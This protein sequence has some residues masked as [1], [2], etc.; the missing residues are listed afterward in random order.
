MQRRIWVLLVVVV[1]VLLVAA[2]LLGTQRDTLAALLDDAIA[3]ARL[4]RLLN[5]SGV[6]QLDFGPT[7]DPALVALGEALFFDKLLSGNRDI[8]CATC[9]PPA[10]AA[11]GGL[12]LSL[13]ADSERAPRNIADLFNRGSPEWTTLFWDG[14]V[15]LSADGLDTPAGDA[16][17]P[18]LETALQAQAMFPVIAREEMRGFAGDHTADGQLNEL[19][20]AGDTEFSVIWAR[21]RQRLLAAPGYVELFRAA[22]PAVPTEQLRFEH[23]AVALAAYEAAAFTFRDSPWDRYLAGDRAALPEQA[24]RGALLFYGEAGCAQCHSGNLLTDQQFH[25]IGVP[26]IGP[27]KRSDERLDLGRFLETGQA[28]DRYAFRTPPLRNVTLTAP[29]MHNGAYADLRAAVRHHLNPVGS[30]LIYDPTTLPA[31]YQATSHAGSEVTTDILETL[32]ARLAT[33]PMLTDEQL[34]DLMAFLAALTSPAA[35]D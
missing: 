3:D 24:R 6:T 30:L 26:Q 31:T 19:A 28:T 23:A 25:N 12:P 13:A 20:T 17:P 8:A 29:Y 14:R 34:A 16:L 9:H 2:A 35:A 4:S 32:D 15:S 11:A 22:Y 5:E 1:A 21:L 10:P 7:P 33:P 18:L 27:S